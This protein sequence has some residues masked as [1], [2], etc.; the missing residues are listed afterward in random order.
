MPWVPAEPACGADARRSNRHSGFV[1]LMVF[2]VAALADAKVI[3]VVHE[4]DR[5][6][7]L[8]HLEI[9]PVFAEQP[10]RCPVD[11]W[12][13]HAIHLIGEDGQLVSH[14]MGVVVNALFLAPRERIKTTYRVC[15]VG[16]TMSWMWRIGSPPFDHA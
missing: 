2:V 9:Q 6:Y 10:K 14:V 1:E 8:D 7:P 11:Q 3:I 15:G 16:L 12:Q 5:L 13:R 4:L